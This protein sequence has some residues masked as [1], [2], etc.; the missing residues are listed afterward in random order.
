MGLRCHPDA[1]PRSCNISYTKTFSNPHFSGLVLGI[2]ILLWLFLASYLMTAFFSISNLCTPR[3][4]SVPFI[5]CCMDTKRLHSLCSLANI[6]TDSCP[7]LLK[8]KF[9]FSQANVNHTLYFQ[10][11]CFCWALNSAYIYIN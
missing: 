8:N 11:N 2:S 5:R 4:R 7:L 6:L 3:Y 10:V 9:P 1:P